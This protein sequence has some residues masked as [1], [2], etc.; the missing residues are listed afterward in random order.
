MNSKQSLLFTSFKLGPVKLRNRTI[1]AAAFEGM[2]PG[3]MPSGK[4]LQ[5]HH[6][7][8]AGG[9]GM[10]TVAYAAVNRSALSFPHQLLLNKEAVPGLCEL[11][12]AVHR[13][14]AACSIQIGHCGNMTKRSVTGIRPMAPSARINLYGPTYPRAMRHD[15]IDDVVK[16]FGHA[17]HMAR[18]SGFDAVEVHAGHGYLI[19]QFLSPYTNRRKDEFGGSLANR[20]RFMHMVMEE[21]KKAA[22]SD[23]AVLVKMN[24]SDGFRGG[25]EMDECLEV[26]RMLEK[27]GADALVLSGG[28]VSRTPM[29]VLRGAMP[30]KVFA[31]FI[32]ER[33]MKFF[34]RQFGG[35]LVRE[36]PFSEAYFLEDALKF[37]SIVKLPLVY[38]GGLISRK[39]IDEVL[40]KGFE[41]VAVARALF[42]DTDFVNKIKDQKDFRSACDI[43]N[44][45]IAVMYTNEADCIQ[46]IENPDPAIIKMMK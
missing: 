40:N 9:V 15:D 42:K 12:D 14:G 11:T 22:A 39:K 32:K 26:A 6:A 37:R 29:Y 17:V 5:Y 8:A 34:V 28:F 20:A 31:H 25:M 46:N 24:M 38:V 18:E 19:S 21:V 30:V 23:M 43:C 44:Y 13:E 4:L 1:R 10:T 45:C 16:A 41:M 3:N 33:W 7:V 35:F 2:C 36:V 27:A